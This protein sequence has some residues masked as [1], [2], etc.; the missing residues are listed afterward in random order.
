MPINV[1]VCFKSVTKNSENFSNL[2]VTTCFN[3]PQCLPSLPSS[4]FLFIKSFGNYKIGK[5]FVISE[6]IMVD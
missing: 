5:V 1:S 3:V 2:S 4:K 6:N